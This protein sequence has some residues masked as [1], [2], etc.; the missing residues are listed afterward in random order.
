MVG[1]SLFFYKVF[2]DALAGKENPVPARPELRPLVLGTLQDRDQLRRRICIRLQ[3]RIEQGLVEEVEGLR[4]QG[5]SWARLDSLGLEYRFVAN[6]LQN[7]IESRAQLHEL[8][9][10]AISQFARRQ[11]R[12][13]R[14]MERR[15]IEIHWLESSSA[16][17]A[18]SK[19][20]EYF[21][22]ARKAAR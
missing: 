13:F 5:V 17:A 22:P 19:L 2:N 15:G 20:Q 3:Q 11:L 12:W 9:A 18:E 6:Y 7:K 8:L 10:I 16:A 1:E 14:R 21:G 4:D